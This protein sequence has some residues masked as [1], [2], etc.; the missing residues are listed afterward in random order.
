M[1]SERTSL[2]HGDLVRACRSHCRSDARHR[3]AAS[4]GG[5]DCLP[6]THPFPAHLL[7]RQSSRPPQ[8]LSVRPLQPGPRQIV[9]LP[10][11]ESIGIHRHHHS[12]HPLFGQRNDSQ[13]D[14]ATSHSSQTPQSASPV[15]YPYVFPCQNSSRKS[16]P[17]SDTCSSCPSPLPQTQQA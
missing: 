14:S 8:Q 16:L 9:A 3:V 5:T 17:R 13:P 15:L 11:I 7:R 2:R 1:R 12:S 10:G 6:T 4:A